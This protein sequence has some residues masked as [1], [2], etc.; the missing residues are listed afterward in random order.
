MYSRRVERFWDKQLFRAQSADT[1]SWIVF[2]LSIH[3][4]TT[5]KSFQMLMSGTCPGLLRPRLNLS[6]WELHELSLTR[7]CFD[8]HTLHCSAAKL[9]ALWF[10]NQASYYSLFTVRSL[11]TVKG[12][13][14]ALIWCHSFFSLKHRIIKWGIC[15]KTKLKVAWCCSQLLSMDTVTVDHHQLIFV[16][17]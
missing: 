13:T 3:C 16:R 8:S 6:T 7:K 15:Q 9:D 1:S 17:W 11:G 14:V 10:G 2:S 4:L 5:N 12:T